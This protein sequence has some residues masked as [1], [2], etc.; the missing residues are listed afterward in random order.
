M[1]GDEE[2]TATP[3]EGMSLETRGHSTE[4][5]TEDVTE[6]VTEV[7]TYIRAANILDELGMCKTCDDKTASEIVTNII[8]CWEC[9]NNFHAI[10]CKSNICVSSNS[11]FTNQLQPAVTNTGTFSGRFGR[12]L[13]LCDFCITESEKR[14]AATMDDRVSILDKKIDKYNS[15]FRDELKEMKKMLVSLA[16]ASDSPKVLSDGKASTSLET[17]DSIWSDKHRVEMLKQRMVIKGADGKPID[18][19][20]LERA[21]VDKGVAVVTSYQIKDTQ[22]TA[23]VVRSKKDAELLQ[24]KLGSDSPQHEVAKVAT[25]TPT[26]TVTGLSRKYGA[27]ELVNMIKNLD[28][29][30]I[31]NF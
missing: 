11:V 25:R 27:D 29:V 17:K 9:K 30:I 8:Q 3:C 15:G 14:R 6:V 23:I 12:F 20:L 4:D 19:K 16:S 26:I 21:S 1:K 22:D 5:V 24:Q 13:W 18:S 10:G 31:L 28:R 7:V 2:R